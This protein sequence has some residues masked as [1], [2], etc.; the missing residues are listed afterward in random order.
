MNEFQPVTAVAISGAFVF[1]IVLALLGSIK[2]SLAKRLQISETQVGLLLSALNLALAPMMLLS[3]IL[4]DQWG[5]RP[6]MILGSFLVC[7]AVYGLTLRRT[8]LWAVAAILL[9]GLGAACVSTASV[10]LMPRAF[11]D[12]RPDTLGAAL[13]LGMAFF[14]LGALVTP[15][16]VD[17]LL[18]RIAFARTL[19]LLAVVCLAPA[20]L[21]AATPIP[22]EESRGVN[23]GQV[24]QDRYL[25]LAALV[26]FLYAPLEAS[27]GAWATTFLIEMGNQ[28]RRVAW[29]L[30][31]FWL[32]FLAS[33]LAAAFLHIQASSWVIVALALLAAVLLGN[34]SS[35]SHRGRSRLELLALGAV[36]GPMLPTL[37]AL[38]FAHFAPA[39][40]GTAYGAM[41]AFGSLGSL[42]MCPA[43]GFWVRRHAV[44]QAL[45][46]PMFI[47]LGMGAAALV[48]G[49]YPP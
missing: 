48:L 5:V 24:L 41:Y 37:V 11:Y 22:A 14:A 42:A 19:A 1:G 20:L 8:F 21:A 30:S 47:A 17:T 36:L 35:G 28:E 40:R 13:N 34:M 38:V 39:E 44:Q 46:I 2:L 32:T 9:V 27:V 43:I 12:G 23:L 16:L 25:W 29:L 15:A 6:V 26:F 3:G 31:G 10:V 7:V 49:L 45:R 18:R 4:I 33:R